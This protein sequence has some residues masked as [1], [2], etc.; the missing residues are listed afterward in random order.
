MTGKGIELY[1]SRRD[2]SH[3]V[4]PRR[5]LLNNSYSDRVCIRQTLDTPFNFSFNDRVILFIQRQLRH[6]N[7]VECLAGRRWSFS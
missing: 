4:I 6:H 7:V 1:V 3:S 5:T 2:I